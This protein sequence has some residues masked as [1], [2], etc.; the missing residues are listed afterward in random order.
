MGAVW[1]VQAV[2]SQYRC[3]VGTW[4]SGNQPAGGVLLLMAVPRS[5]FRDV[6]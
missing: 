6:W 3:W 1:L 4:G 5:P 2:P